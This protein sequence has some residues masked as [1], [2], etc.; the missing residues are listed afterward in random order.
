VTS[1][2]FCMAL[3]G[4]VLPPL[5]KARGPHRKA[6]QAFL[7]ARV[8][9]GAARLSATF[10]RGCRGRIANGRRR[11]VVYGVLVGGGRGSTAWLAC[12]DRLTVYEPGR[13]CSWPWAPKHS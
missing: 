1:P 3:T 9:C 7:G 12:C 11:G 10:L 8:S 2:L 5:T 6:V 13:A 4:G